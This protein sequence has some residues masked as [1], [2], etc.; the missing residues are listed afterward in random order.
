[1]SVEF[2]KIKTTFVS[3][4][5]IFWLTVFVPGFIIGLLTALQVNLEKFSFVSN[6]NLIVTIGSIGAILSI[7]MWSLNPLSDFQCS[8]EKSRSLISRVV[9][10]TNFVTTWVVLGFLFFELIVFFSDINLMLFFNI[11]KPLIPLMAIFFGFIPTFL[12]LYFSYQKFGIN[13]II[14]LYDFASKKAFGEAVFYNLI[15]VLYP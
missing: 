14:S 15:L 9:D 3:K 6:F 10:T 1:M 4:F 5:N 7:F 12:S 8:T 13:G 2:E 11:W